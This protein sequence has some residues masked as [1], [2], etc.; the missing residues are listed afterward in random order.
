M[1][2]C[3][4]IPFSGRRGSE[5]T[6]K[7]EWQTERRGQRNV[8]QNACLGEVLLAGGQTARVQILALQPSSCFWFEGAGQLIFFSVSV[9]S[10]L[11]WESNSTCFVG[12]Q[13]VINTACRSGEHAV[14]LES[15]SAVG[16]RKY[17]IGV[18]C[19]FCITGQAWTVLSH[20]QN[21]GKIWAMWYWYHSL[22]N[23]MFMCKIKIPTALVFTESRWL[24]ISMYY[25]LCFGWGYYFMVNL[26][27]VCLT[28]G[29]YLPPRRLL[30]H[31]WL[32]HALEL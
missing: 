25:T 16:S 32:S 13:W 18:N 20:I 3:R 7:L 23:Y 8:Q 2:H 15:T 28:I 19:C 6:C 9:S 4:W 17:F 30:N 22:K 26:N 14:G 5:P 1:E 29:V 27:L 10:T 24:G 12:L 31:V 21:R 11:K